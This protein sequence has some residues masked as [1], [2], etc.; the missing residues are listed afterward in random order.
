MA[1]SST[2]QKVIYSGNGSTT[3]FP[4]TF[5]FLQNGHVA[6]THIAAAGDK[7]PWVEGTHYTLTGAGEDS[8]GTLTVDTSPVDYTPDSGETLVIER[9]PPLTQGT[10]L[11]L[12]GRFPS[13]TV[14]RMVDYGVMLAQFLNARVAR[15]I[16][17][18]IEDTAAI[19]ELPAKAARAGKVMGFDADGDPAVSESDLADIDG[20][21]VAATEQAEAAA[22]SALSA[23]GSA[24]A[25]S[26]SASGASASAI[27]AA[28][29]AA[30]ASGAIGGLKISANDTT[31]APLA[32][33]LVAGSGVTLTENNDG[34]NETLT[35][36]VIAAETGDLTTSFRTSKMGWVL[37]DGRTIGD[38][39]SGGTNRANA[40]TADLFALLWTNLANAEAAVSGGRGA[41]AAAD[42]AA[43]KT[44]TLPDARGR[45]LIGKDNMGGTAANQVTSGVSG[46][47]GTVLGRGGGDERM[48][49]HQHANTAVTV[50][51]GAHTHTYARSD[52]VAG[53]TWTSGPDGNITQSSQATGSDGAHTHTVTV[54][55]VDAG[56]GAA[57]N[58]QPSLVA[59]VFI[60][61]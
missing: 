8:G 22:A 32:T 43:H 61:L 34:G 48:H 6:V 40:D 36:G 57:Q 50:S 59:N 53:N 1:L 29:S 14:E 9:A 13:R 2:T 56:A 17:Q 54:T 47:D 49:Q 33:K 45:T 16:R 24:S 3:A 31:A 46:L 26:A 12:G 27:S 35:V 7:T 37:L 52:I 21:L 11:P 28:A 18:P 38:A 15:A 41:S 19:G 39:S 23:S 60:K 4:V 58:V 10:E 30:E 51:G 44:L 20:I 42:F 55:N 25:A 5:N